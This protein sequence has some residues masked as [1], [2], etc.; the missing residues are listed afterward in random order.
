MTRG[1]VVLVAAVVLAACAVASA[2]EPSQLIRTNNSGGNAVTINEIAGT[3]CWRQGQFTYRPA[4]IPFSACSTTT[5]TSPT[6]TTTLAPTTTSTTVAP[7][8]TTTTT[9]TVAP[10]P[11]TTVPPDGAQFVETFDGNSGLERFRHA[12]YHR[13]DFLVA[14]TQW[15]GDHDVAMCGDPHT[16][17][18]TVHR[19]NPDESFYVCNNHLMTSVGDTSGYSIAWFSPDQTFNEQTRVSWDVNVTNLGFRQ[20]WEVV[21]VPVAA[22]DL[23]CHEVFPCGLPQ[24][25]Y[26]DDTVMLNNNRAWIDGADLDPWWPSDY[27]SPS[28]VDPEGCTSKAIRRS[29]SIVDN[30]NGTITFTING[31][32]FTYP[33]VFPSGDW[34]VVFKDHNYTPD[35]DGVP[36]G[37]TWHWDSIAIT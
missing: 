23:S 15:E 37:H 26:P 32:A 10:P 13:D 20:W 27:C 17:S 18:R 6:T 8:A 33:G 31:A 14:Q 4:G 34:K 5:T 24:V 19:A 9:T 12:V 25:G 1:F 30:L 11:T 2:A 35:K 21:I 36:V 3:P 22:P 29:F 28:P 16:T 7:S